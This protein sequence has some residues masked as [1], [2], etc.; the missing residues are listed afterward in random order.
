MLVLQELLGISSC[1]AALSFPRVVIKGKLF[2]T[3]CYATNYKRNNSVV[4]L[5][6]GVICEIVNIAKVNRDC[7]CLLNVGSSCILN[8]N[9]VLEIVLIGITVQIITRRLYD[10]FSEMNLLEF[11]KQRDTQTPSTTVAFIPADIWYKCVCISNEEHDYFIVNDLQF[12][13]G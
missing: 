5:K 4:L 3:K 12:E 10:E 2:C 7:Q 9:D 1:N 11:L 6:N 13:R 8:N